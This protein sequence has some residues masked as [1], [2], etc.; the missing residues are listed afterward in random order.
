MLIGFMEMYGNVTAKNGTDI[1][2][3]VGGLTWKKKP[4]GYIGNIGS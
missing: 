3:I 1:E 4:Q 2:N